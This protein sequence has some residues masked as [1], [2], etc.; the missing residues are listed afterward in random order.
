[1]NTRTKTGYFY[2]QFQLKSA[3]EK[4]TKA[5]KFQEQ[6]AEVR[7]MTNDSLVTDGSCSFC[8][9]LLCRSVLGHRQHSRHAGDVNVD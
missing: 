6:L 2:G 3:L 8:S 4:F 5:G 1:M 9:L 7:M